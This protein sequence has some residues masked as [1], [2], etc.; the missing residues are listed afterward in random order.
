MGWRA[1]HVPRL[2]IAPAPHI[3]GPDSHGTMPLLFGCSPLLSRM[4]LRPCLAPLS[5][6]SRGGAPRRREG[7]RRCTPSFLGAPW[8][9]VWRLD[10]ICL[11]PSATRPNAFAD[12]LSLACKPTHRAH[13]GRLRLSC[14]TLR[15]EHPARGARPAAPLSR[16]PVASRPRRFL[17]AL[18]RACRGPAVSRHGTLALG[19][20][21]FTRRGPHRPVELRSD[22]RAQPHGERRNGTQPASP[23]AYHSSNIGYATRRLPVSQTLVRPSRYFFPVRT[24]R[25]SSSWRCTSSLA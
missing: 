9:L 19:V 21:W 24:T 25:M 3:V 7:C 2:S 12:C 1:P 15:R 10:H 5:K 6:R 4:R 11:P 22:C 23:H 14:A 8:R 20:S 16:T 13:L 18:P 17:P